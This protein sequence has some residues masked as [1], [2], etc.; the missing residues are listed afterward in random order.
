M[1]E[2]F[3]LT[4]SQIGYLDVE[5]FAEVEN[6][7]WNEAQII[8]KIGNEEKTICWIDGKKVREFLT[9]MNDIIQKYKV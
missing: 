1:S 2:R 5:V 8:A 3:K 9:E 7:T 4:R 6:K